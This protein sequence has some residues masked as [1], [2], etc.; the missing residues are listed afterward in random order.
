MRTEVASG[1]YKGHAW[2]FMG[3]HKWGYKLVPIVLTHIRGLIT[4]LITTR[5]PPSNGPTAVTCIVR[6]PLKVRQGLQALQ[7]VLQSKGL[8]FRV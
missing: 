8:R 2:K 4:P 3:S 6:G 7:G 1:F 5:E